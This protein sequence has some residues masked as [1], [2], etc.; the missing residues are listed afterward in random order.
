MQKLPGQAMQRQISRIPAQRQLDRLIAG[1]LMDV[2]P[3]R[4]AKQHAEKIPA[5]GLGTFGTRLT[6]GQRGE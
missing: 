1:D 6:V 4:V 3:K 5:E 2:S